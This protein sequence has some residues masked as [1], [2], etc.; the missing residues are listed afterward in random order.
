MYVSIRD[1]LWNR[2]SWALD[3]EKKEKILPS[4]PHLT[5]RGQIHANIATGILP[6]ALS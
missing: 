5:H 2:E 3:E 4:Q 6:C 1:S